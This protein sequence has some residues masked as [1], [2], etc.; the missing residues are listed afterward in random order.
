MA[1]VP[2]TA[3]LPSEADLTSHIV[4]VRRYHEENFSEVQDAL[5]HVQRE[6]YR[7]TQSESPSERTITRLYTMLSGVWCEARLHKLLYEQGAFE[8]AERAVIYAQS[9]VEQKWKKALDVA[10]RKHHGIPHQ[11]ALS[12]EI[13]DFSRLKIYE[14]VLEWIEKYFVSVIELRNK[15][16]H[17]QWAKPFI[18]HQAGWSSS[19]DFKIA[20][21]SIVA[22]K[23]ENLLTIERKTKLLQDI[24]VAINNLAVDGQRY[25]ATDFDQQYKRIHSAIKSL[26]NAD[27]P[28]HRQKLIDGYKNSA[29]QANAGVCI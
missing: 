19:L 6:L 16:A 20:N 17:G 28:S 4:D 18:N 5:T 13:V 21:N 2:T 22:L 1:L 29:L 11:V 7:A 15:I 8:D 24:A 14:Q 27:F 12:S 25:G 3:S 9:S 26:E 23:G 10:F